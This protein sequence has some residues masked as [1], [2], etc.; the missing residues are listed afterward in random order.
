MTSSNEI[1]KNL[2]E[3]S[4]DEFLK[5]HWQRKY[6]FVSE[7]FKDSLPEF[8]ADELAGLSLEEDVE[9]RLII[10]SK[11]DSNPENQWTLKHGPFL[12]SDFTT[13]PESHWTLLVQAVDFWAPEYTEFLSRFRFLP[14]WRI[15]DIMISYATDQGGVGPHF[16]YYDVFL[17][18]L[19]GER[20][21]RIG[22]QCD[23]STEKVEGSPLN[24][25]RHFKTEAEFLAKPGDLLY[26]PAGKAHWGIAQGECTTISVG[27][28]APSY[29][30]I[31]SHFSGELCNTLPSNYRYSDSRKNTEQL[32]NCGEIS[33][34]TIENIQQQLVSIISNPEALASWF[35]R[36][37]TESKY[38]DLCPW[39]QSTPSCEL[40][41]NTVKRLVKEKA[42]EFCPGIRTAYFP[43]S[44]ETALLF[45][46]GRE[47]LCHIELAKALSSNLQ[48]SSGSLQ[49]IAEM[50][51]TQ[52]QIN[53]YALLELLIEKELLL[54][55]S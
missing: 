15:D 37:M 5:H 31:L 8:P 41:A 18:Q 23:D 34:A 16:D 4:I 46:D 20:L 9:S 43:K 10:E 32:N 14:N 51:D 13:L 29:S 17:I 48:F 25:I 1:L 24:Q 35:G 28:R 2:G 52:Q 39:S 7:C 54:V 40:N 3:L 19:E 55:Q 44:Q 45:I 42:F 49:K 36:Y 27:F 53:T 30:E 50:G 26:I 6:L 11:Q 47:F 12:E 38:E 22:Q 33:V 21:W